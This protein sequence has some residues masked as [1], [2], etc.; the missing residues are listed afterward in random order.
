MEG[1]LCA[2]P[3]MLFE[4]VEATSSWALNHRVLVYEILM[5]KPS[6]ALAVSVRPT[7]FADGKS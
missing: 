6:F 4:I 1:T 7:K 3:L 5:R 2:A